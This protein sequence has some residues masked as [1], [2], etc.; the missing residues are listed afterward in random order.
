MA[1]G[2]RTNL[3][4]LTEAVGDNSPVEQRGEE[5]APAAIGTVKRSDC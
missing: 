2:R 1:Q 3:A 4:S 5:T